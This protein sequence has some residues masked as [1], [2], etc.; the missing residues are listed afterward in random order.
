VEVSDALGGERRYVTLPRPGGAC[1][2]HLGLRLG[3]AFEPL[4][5]SAW[6][7]VPPDGPCAEAG[8]WPEPPETP[9]R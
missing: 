7:P 8:D 3:D 2:A 9:P 6:V 1:R 4:L 5:T